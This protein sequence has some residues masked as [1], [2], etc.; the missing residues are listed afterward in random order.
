MQKSP[1]MAVVGRKVGQAEEH[2]DEV[3]GWRRRRK[4]RHFL[5][6]DC[7]NVKK[8]MIRKVVEVNN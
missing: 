7:S 2:E 4:R 5:C 1:V 6:R 3:E 8:K